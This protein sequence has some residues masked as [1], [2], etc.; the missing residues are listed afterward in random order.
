MPNEHTHSNDPVLRY[1]RLF[2]AAQDG[3]LLLSYPYGLIEDANPYILNMLGYT[4]EELLGKELWEIGVLADKE[5]AQIVHE[6][7]VTNGFVRYED[8]DF[9]N[10]A[11]ERLAVELICNSYRV[12]GDIVI[13]CNV[14]NITD[15]KRTEQALLKE[16]AKNL[17]QLSDTISSLSNVIEARDP[18]TAGHQRRVAELACEIAKN[19]GLD[20]FEIEGLKMACL[21]HDI[22]KISI[23]V[24][25]LTKPT[26]ITPLEI[27]LL[28]GHVQSGYEILKPLNFPWPISKYILQHHERLDGSGYPN[29]LKGEAICIQARIM[30]VADTLEAMISDRPYRRAVGLDAAL[31]E[32]EKNKNT[33]YDG[34]VVDACLRLFRVLGYKL[35]PTKNAQF[36]G[37]AVRNSGVVQNNVS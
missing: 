5:K 8:L 3:I 7:I 32:I 33:L 21:I 26:N 12:D 4:K 29:A 31:E 2:E 35:P 15:R 14:R 16:Q 9:Q 17:S 34:V 28:R 19:I 30:A 37:S 36:I 22:G 25:I 10:K 24:E 23:P 13:Q 27:A 1:T 18:F 20:P 11:G 6:S